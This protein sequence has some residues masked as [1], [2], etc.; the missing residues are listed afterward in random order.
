M[1]QEVCSLLSAWSIPFILMAVP[2]YAYLKGV[3]VYEVFVEGAG[4]GFQTALRIMPFLIAMMV[5]IGILRDSGA[6][7]CIINFIRPA[8]NYLGVP[9]Q[10]T[11]LA[12]MRPLSGTGTMGLATEILSRFGPDSMCG[13]IAST[14]M[15]STDTTFYILTVYFGAVGVTKPRYCLYAGLIGDLFGFFASVILCGTMFG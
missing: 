8:L 7:D 6:M 13:R 2:L 1:L 15:G 14:I 11:P 5:A 3:K 4:E 9:E 12:I 10:L